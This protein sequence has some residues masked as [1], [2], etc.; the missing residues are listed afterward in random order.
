M[1]NNTTHKLMR[2]LNE[3]YILYL[4]VNC[5][6]IHIVENRFRYIYYLYVLE[7]CEVKLVLVRIILCI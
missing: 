7:N 6:Y 1:K 2:L 4:T 5:N 3:M